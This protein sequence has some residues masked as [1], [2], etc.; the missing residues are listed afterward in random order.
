MRSRFSII[1]QKWHNQR[2]SEHFRYVK[3]R[4]SHSKPLFF[5][6]VL[7]DLLDW[8]TFKYQKYIFYQ[9][10]MLKIEGLQMSL[11]E[12]AVGWEDWSGS[13]SRSALIGQHYL[14]MHQK[15]GVDSLWG[16]KKNKY[17]AMFT[18]A[19]HLTFV[20][21]PVLT[22]TVPSSLPETCCFLRPKFN[23]LERLGNWILKRWA[24]GRGA[25]I[26]KCARS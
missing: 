22:P 15:W 20:N 2:S 21:M 18:V 9:Y 16:V 10:T 25:W 17:S 6:Q 24:G 12:G 7:K 23:L 14:S 1:L 13:G 5:T 3:W 26:E 8:V 11:T 19:Q 4:S